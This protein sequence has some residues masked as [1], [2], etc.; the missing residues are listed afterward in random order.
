[1]EG[2]LK[3]TFILQNN[4]ALMGGTLPGWMCRAF[5]SDISMN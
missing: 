5:F 3:K 1:V 2:L 4:L